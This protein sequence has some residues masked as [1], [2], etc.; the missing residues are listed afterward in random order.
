MPSTY[1]LLAGS[2][3][4]GPCPNFWVDDSTGDVL[5][6]GYVTSAAPPDAVP[7]GEA[8]L[9][10]PAEAWQKLLSRLGR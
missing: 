5:V 1:R 4:N 10:I 2:C 3:D 8:V 7:D 9:H 6:Q